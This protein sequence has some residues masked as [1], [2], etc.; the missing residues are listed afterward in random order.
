MT[1]TFHIDTFASADVYLEVQQFYAEHMRLL[2]DGDADAWAAGFTGD[3]VFAEPGRLQE[4]SGREA[5]RTSARARVARLAA[6]QV[7]VR[8]W[9]GMLT[10]AP[11]PDE[12]LHTRYYALAF[13]IA[14]DRAISLLASVDCRDVL[15]RHDGR[16]RIESR[17]LR[18]DGVHEAATAA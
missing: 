3:A 7:R 17:H 15:V 10:V 6:D 16:L 8:H 2:D 1:D 12:R 9:F 11:Q 14:A 5:I 4:L 18:L 13:S